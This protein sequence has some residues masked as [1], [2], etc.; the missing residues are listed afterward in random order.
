MFYFNKSLAT[1]INTRYLDFLSRTA[2]VQI[3]LNALM[4]YRTA[5]F[6]FSPTFDLH[7]STLT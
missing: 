3:K 7:F 6:F 5:L 4:D 2:T 1:I